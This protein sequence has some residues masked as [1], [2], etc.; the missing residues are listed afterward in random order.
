MVTVI[1]GTLNWSGLRESGQSRSVVMYLRYFVSKRRFE[2]TL[3]AADG[4]PL[5]QRIRPRL[6]LRREKNDR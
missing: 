6:A 4:V 2:S 5:C 1:C 3:A